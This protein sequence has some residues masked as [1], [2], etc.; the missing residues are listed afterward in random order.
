M[1]QSVEQSGGREASVVTLVVGVALALGLGFAVG[2]GWGDHL[3][4]RDANTT[5]S[6]SGSGVATAPEMEAAVDRALRARDSLDRTLALNR[7]MD[8]L[9]AS[10]VSGAADAFSRLIVAAHNCDIRAFLD[11]WTSFDPQAAREYVG[12][13]TVASK[14]SLG[15]YETAMAATYYGGALDTISHVRN[16]PSNVLQDIGTQGLIEGWIRREDIDEATEYL[17]T[18]DDGD[19][20]DLYLNIFTAGIYFRR[21]TEGMIDWTDAIDVDAHDGFKRTAFEAAL[22]NAAYQDPERAARWYAENADQDFARDTLWRVSTGWI[23]KDPRAAIRWLRALPPSTDRYSALR[24]ALVHWN[25]DQPERMKAWLR[26]AEL[27]DA[28]WEYLGSQ[29]APERRAGAGRRE[30]GSR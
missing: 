21:G 12:R 20:R 16:L 3:A 25:A 5:P 28:E 2:S 19:L 30:A 10:N 17:L 15:V 27:D 26:Q 1:S 13:W 6:A 29:F 11:V 7:L 22:T 18:L 24:R 9:D 23:R 14:R 8:G 4:G